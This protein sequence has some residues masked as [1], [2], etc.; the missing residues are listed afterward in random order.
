MDNIILAKKYS[1]WV[2]FNFGYLMHYYPVQLKP[3][4]VYQ[5]FERFFFVNRKFTQFCY[6][7]WEFKPKICYFCVFVALKNLWIRMGFKQ[8]AILWCPY[9]TVYHPIVRRLQSFIKECLWNLSSTYL[10][11]LNPLYL[12]VKCELYFIQ[13]IIQIEVF[14]MCEDKT[15]S[16]QLRISYTSSKM[17]KINIT[18]A[19]TKTI[20]IS[21]YKCWYE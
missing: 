21:A 9:S 5:C 12:L 14:F 8:Q 10:L 11:W 1:K 18:K 2:S 17:Q 16:I 4:W 15:I 7:F 19:N 6:V 3:W 13:I 20:N